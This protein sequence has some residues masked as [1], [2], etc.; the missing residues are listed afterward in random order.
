MALQVDS[1]SNVI[2]CSPASNQGVKSLAIVKYDRDGV[3]LW[4]HYENGAKN[5][6]I[7][8]VDL[9]VD[10]QG[11][12]VLSGASSGNNHDSWIVLKIDR[13]GNKLWQRSLPADDNTYGSLAGGLAIDSNGSI[14]CSGSRTVQ[15]YYDQENVT[16]KYDAQGN[17]VWRTSIPN[18]DHLSNGT[19]F[20][21]LDQLGN[22]YVR[23]QGDYTGYQ[24]DALLAKY[25]ALSGTLQWINRFSTAANADDRFVSLD[26][27]S[28]GN[29]VLAAYSLEVG[30]GP[31]ESHVISYDADGNLRWQVDYSDSG[32]FYVSDAAL[33]QDDNVYVGGTVY[34]D[35]D[36]SSSVYRVSKLTSTGST[37]WDRQSGV[38]KKGV[39]QVDPYVLVDDNDNV[40]L[41]GVAQSPSVAFS[42]D[43]TVVKWSPSG[44]RLWMRKLATDPIQ[45]TS[46]RGYYR[47]GLSPQSGHVYGS[48]VLS[49]GYTQVCIFK[50]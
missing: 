48:N 23:F 26:I 17:Q 14:F 20:P 45:G 10:I 44:Q 30:P 25:D 46:Q 50:L 42:W 11:N 9:K 39:L 32:L 24:G 47:F 38:A 22:V 15:L 19:G 33:D 21:Q 16:V 5:L 12:V 8:V 3:L 6:G 36:K 41:A 37:I 49:K 40:Y 7:Q 27:D 34:S 13:N 35:T 4:T 43:P 18:A 31:Q 28:Q 1:R 2:V 29:P